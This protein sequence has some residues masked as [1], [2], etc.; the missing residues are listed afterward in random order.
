[1]GML[2][3]ITTHLV[4]HLMGFGPLQKLFECLLCTFH[5][6][7]LNFYPFVLPLLFFP[8]HFSVGSYHIHFWLQ[9]QATLLAK[10]AVL[11]GSK[12]LGKLKAP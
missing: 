8:P 7:Q 12:Y 5:L 6:R 2:G 1:M 10:I 11:Q 9:F 3:K 4:L